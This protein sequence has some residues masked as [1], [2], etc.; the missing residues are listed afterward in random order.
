MQINNGKVEDSSPFGFL[1]GN[2]TKDTAVI[3]NVSQTEEK[4]SDTV[5]NQQCFKRAL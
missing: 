4:N 3:K 2:Q 1:I 5:A